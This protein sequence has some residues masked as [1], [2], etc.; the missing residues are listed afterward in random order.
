[1]Q[2]AEQR[3]YTLISLGWVA[4]ADV[5]ALGMTIPT[6]IAWAIAAARA[7][8]AVLRAGCDDHPRWWHG[9]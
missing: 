2:A 7:E 4:H 5:A 8:T 3:N 9:S 6:W 1:M